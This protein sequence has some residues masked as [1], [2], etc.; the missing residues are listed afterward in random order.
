[1]LI[2]NESTGNDLTYVYLSLGSSESGEIGM[3]SANYDFT[4]I[5]AAAWNA[6]NLS[7]FTPY[8]AKASGSAVILSPDAGGTGAPSITTSITVNPNGTNGDSV[9][10]VLGAAGEIS[11]SGSLSAGEWVQGIYSGMFLS[12]SDYNSLLSTFGGDA[13]VY[14]VQENAPVY[15]TVQMGMSS[16]DKTIYLTKNSNSAVVEFTAPI[17]IDDFVLAASQVRRKVGEAEPT[18]EIEP[19][20]GKTFVLTIDGRSLNIPWEASDEMFTDF[21]TGQKYPVWKPAFALQDGAFDFDLVDNG[22][23]VYKIKAPFVEERPVETNISACGAISY[24]PASLSDS[25]PERRELI[26]YEGGSFGGGQAPSEG[27]YGPAGGGQA[28][29]GVGGGGR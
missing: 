15:Y 3:F 9:S 18:S 14:T 2:L 6:S 17:V 29:P 13:D 16:W 20:I 19:N 8:T 10:F 4:K 1:M 22:N 23:T 11:L 24:P 5:I 25:L 27:S 12:N 21:F 28:S 26:H 7:S